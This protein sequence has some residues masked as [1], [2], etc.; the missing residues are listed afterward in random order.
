[1]RALVRIARFV[2]RG[3]RSRRAAALGREAG[4]LAR[5]AAALRAD[6]EAA[7]AR[8]RVAE[9][10]LELLAAVVARDRERVKAETSRYVA[11]AAAGLGGVNG[12]ARGS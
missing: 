12:F 4:R 7:Q 2:R 3:L 8:L 6:L 1:V 9:L 10:E 11:R 5:E